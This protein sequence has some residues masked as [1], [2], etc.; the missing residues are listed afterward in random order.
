MFRTATRGWNI[1]CENELVLVAAI[2]PG[3][4]VGYA[5]VDSDG[6]LLDNRVL[7]LSEMHLLEVPADATL[8]VGDGTG[9]YAVQDILA[10]RNLKVERVDERGTSFEG[11]ELY[12]RDHLPCLP[13]RW[14]PRGLWWPPRSIDDYAA[15][16]I[17]LRFLGRAGRHDR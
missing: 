2:D 1:Q 4:N 7:P 6:R 14:L 17:A 8:I 9:S 3:K 5:L 10:R 13:W 12:F 16:A 15:Y 11:R